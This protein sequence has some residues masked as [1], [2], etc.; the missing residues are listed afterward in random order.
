MKLRQMMEEEFQSFIAKNLKLFKNERFSRVRTRGVKGERKN[1]IQL[2]LQYCHL[3]QKLISYFLTKNK[4][5]RNRELEFGVNR[6]SDKRIEIN[7][8]NEGKTGEKRRKG[9]RKQKINNLRRFKI[10][11][12]K[13]RVKEEYRMNRGIFKFNSKKPLKKKKML[14]INPQSEE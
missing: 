10:N 7:N 3:K 1:V 8:D 14:I 5:K 2:F 6:L 11:M 13:L 12:N 9:R 4:T